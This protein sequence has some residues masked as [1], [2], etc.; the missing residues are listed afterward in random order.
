MRL[1]VIYRAVVIVAEVSKLFFAGVCSYCSRLTLLCKFASGYN[2]WNNCV[3]HGW[4]DA[5]VDV[6]QVSS[7]KH[8]LAVELEHE[9]KA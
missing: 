2:R 3:E 5:L 7:L 6:R 4:S 9:E 8:V 1:F